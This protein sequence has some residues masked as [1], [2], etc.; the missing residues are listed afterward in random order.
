MQKLLLP[1]SSFVNITVTTESKLMI[2]PARDF[3]EYEIMVNEEQICELVR[4]VCVDI[5]R[6]LM[7]GLGGLWFCKMST[8]SHSREVVAYF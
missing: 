1:K 6:K 7:L 3:D 5:F 4:L 8:T 2:I